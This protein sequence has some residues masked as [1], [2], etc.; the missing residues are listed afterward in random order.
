MWKPMDCLSDEARFVGITV[1]SQID[2]GG[3][4][5]AGHS[6]D[7]DHRL[8]WAGATRSLVVTDLRLGLDD[9]AAHVVSAVRADRVRGNGRAALGAIGDLRRLLVVVGAT[10]AGP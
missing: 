1:V 6:R 7:R 4:C 9:L 2:S 5:R 3:H 8:V 10:G